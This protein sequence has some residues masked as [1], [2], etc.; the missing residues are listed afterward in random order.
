MKATGLE[1]VKAILWLFCLRVREPCYCL[2][3]WLNCQCH[4][5]QAWMKWVQT[6]LKTVATIM[7]PKSLWQIYGEIWYIW[8]EKFMIYLTRKT[9]ATIMWPK[10][11]WHIWRYLIFDKKNVWY[12]WRE[13]Y[14]IYLTRNIY[15]IFDEKNCFN[16]HMNKVISTNMEIFE[17][18]QNN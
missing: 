12:I 10:S 15:D 4:G 9:V 13:K 18:G 2:L 16:Y 14:L 1:L 11:F 8:R 3:C 5:T 17:T 6:Y 7:W